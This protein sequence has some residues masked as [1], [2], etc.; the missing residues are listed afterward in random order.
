MA[1]ESRLGRR[2]SWWS[3][4]VTGFRADIQPGPGWLAVLMC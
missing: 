3:M 2:L 1:G 4:D